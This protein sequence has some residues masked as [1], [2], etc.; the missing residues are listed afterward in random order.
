MQ[1][2][3]QIIKFWYFIPT[4]TIWS[5]TLIQHYDWGLDVMYIYLWSDT[6]SLVMNWCYIL[7]HGQRRAALSGDSSFPL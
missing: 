2:F 5:T 4:V 6:G 1:N 3:E 7:L